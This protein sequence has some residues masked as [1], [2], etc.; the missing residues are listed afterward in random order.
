[1]FYI[2]MEPLVR[3]VWPQ[4][5]ITWTRLIQGNW[6]DPMVSRSI[7][8]GIVALILLEL[9]N[10]VGYFAVSLI[11]PAIAE[12]SVGH[13]PLMLAG[14]PELFGMVAANVPHA[15]FLSFLLLFLILGVR[16]AVRKDSIAFVIL[17]VLV[18]TLSTFSRRKDSDLELIL[19]NF[20]YMAVVLLVYMLV[21]IRF[22]LLAVVAFNFAL[23][24]VRSA[25]LT[26]DSRAWYYGHAMFFLGLVCLIVLIA[27]YNAVGS[28]KLGTSS[29]SPVT[30]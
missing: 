10:S 29:K 8:A 12:M 19:I 16:L 18:C 14:T 6:R 5:L 27:C 17:V 11:T 13:R 2:A 28:R 9:H 22:G 15:I 23:S 3:R 24:M 7:L 20:Y 26:L 25:P 1:M 21:L 4:A 30:Q